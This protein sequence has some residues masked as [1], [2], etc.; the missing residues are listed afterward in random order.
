MNKGKMIAIIRLWNRANIINQH[1]LI[2]RFI[3]QYGRTN[4]RQDIWMEYLA[5]EFDIRDDQL[6]SQNVHSLTQA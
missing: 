2:R 5:G 3:D 4:I 1:I 6:M